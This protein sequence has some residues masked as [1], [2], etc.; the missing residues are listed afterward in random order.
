[1]HL[2]KRL[3]ENFIARSDKAAKEGI[4]TGLK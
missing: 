2:Y 4:S 1:M 3:K